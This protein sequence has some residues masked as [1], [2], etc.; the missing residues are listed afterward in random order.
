ML[1]KLSESLREVLRKVTNLSHVDKEV[2]NQIV[3]DIQR[4]L[5]LGD[6]NVSLTLKLSKEVERR[7]LAETP[8][9]GMPYK[10][11][12]IKIIYEEITNVLGDL[13]TIPVKKQK[14]MS[15]G[16]FGQGKTTTCGK[17][18]Y[19]FQKKRFTVGLLAL[20]IH[21]PAAY[22]QLKQIAE[23]LH[24]EFYGEKDGKDA[25]KILI[26]GLEKLKNV[27]IIVVDT[28]G[29]DALDDNLI[30]ELKNIENILKPDETILVIDAVIGQQAGKQA[31]AFRE[32]VTITGV[33]VTK[34]DGTAKG[35]GALSAVNEVN[36][37]IYFI[38]TGEHIEDLELF[39][40]PRFVS[41]LL[42]M[43]DIETLLEKFESIAS[44]KDLAKKME[45]ISSG[46][47]TL[48]DMYEQME[49][50][51]KLGPLNKLLG[52]IPGI[53]GKV[54]DSKIE[55]T[56]KK[57]KK[58]RYIMDSM[59]KEEM[60]TPGIIKAERVNRIAKGSGTTARDVKELLNYYE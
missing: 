19:Y 11:Y 6:V 26:H 7:A 44:E 30:K 47:F 31:K 25:V 58:F 9:A 50:I 56:Q 28:A 54:N 40:P 37:P 21:R 16:L 57:L 15:V 55:E 12:L 5:L 18:A 48:K 59:T 17:I 13:H 43:G 27:D 34:M 23:Q 35:G 8:P 36:A 53:S 32:A 3:K 24:T 29:R 4:A 2:V 33:I 60:E 1:E 38:G 49:S 41:K 10:E 22:D 51:N 52:M 39:N 14:I 20:D 42:G 45:K 46:K